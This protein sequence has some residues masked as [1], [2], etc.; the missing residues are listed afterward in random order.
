MKKLFLCLVAILMLVV[1][2]FWI[3]GTAPDP[4]QDTNGPDKHN[5]QVINDFDIIAGDMG[6]TGGIT[7]KKDLIGSGITIS[8][9][10][11]SGVYDVLWTNFLGK[12]DITLD[13]TALTVTEGNFKACLV[14]D[15]EIVGVIPFNQEDPFYSFRLDDVNGTFSLRIAGESAAFQFSITEDEYDRF[16]HP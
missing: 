4:I 10:G 3:F 1:G 12:S 8:S 2:L 5:L 11:F 13:L 15:D 7:I 16:E 6:M 9:D 14:L